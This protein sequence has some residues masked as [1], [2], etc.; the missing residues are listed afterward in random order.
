MKGLALKIKNRLNG[1]KKLDIATVHV[2]SLCNDAMSGYYQVDYENPVVIKDFLK[3]G[4]QYVGEKIRAMKPDGFNASFLDK[5]IDDLIE[6]AKA[7]IEQQRVSHERTILDIKTGQI[8][9]VKFYKKELEKIS[10]EIEELRKEM[11]KYE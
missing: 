9:T 11:A 6:L 4:S 5:Y 10:H 3:N 8:T 2:G 1:R 7:D